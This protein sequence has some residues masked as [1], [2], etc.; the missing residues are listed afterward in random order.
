VISNVTL[1]PAATVAA[2][3]LAGRVLNSLHGSMPFARLFQP[4]QASADAGDLTRSQPA[5]DR[6]AG[7][8]PLE[9][10]SV[11]TLRQ[12]LDRLCQLLHGTLAGRCA[13]AGVDLSTPIVL[14]RDGA[15]RILEVSGH[16]GR[17]QVETLLESD[18]TLARHLE[19]VFRRAEALRAPA[20][21]FDNP[22]EILV[23]VDQHRASVQIT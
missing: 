3:C 19:S 2:V 18:V 7:A 4:S 17:A 6:N 8:D 5:S 1:V 16:A 23:L 11:A 14:Q 20:A 13:A 10:V 15:G 21:P 22:E 9:P 12:N